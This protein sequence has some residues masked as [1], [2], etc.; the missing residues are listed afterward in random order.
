MYCYH[1]SRISRVIELFSSDD[2]QLHST[3]A[4]FLGNQSEKLLENMMLG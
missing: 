3:S 2:L 4:K 1:E